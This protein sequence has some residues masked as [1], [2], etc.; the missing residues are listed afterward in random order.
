V[1]PK[2]RFRESGICS[3]PCAHPLPKSPLRASVKMAFLVASISAQKDPCVHPF[4]KLPLRASVFNSIKTKIWIRTLVFTTAFLK[5]RMALT[6]DTV[7][8]QVAREIIPV[9]CIPPHRQR[10]NYRPYDCCKNPVVKIKVSDAPT[11]MLVLSESENRMH[12]RV[13][14]ETDARKDL[15]E[16]HCAQPERLF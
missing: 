1:H 14:S 11:H 3:I 4:Q 6:A 10:L 9:D 15:F 12:A 7:R 2:C 5:Q 8:V 13:I 16:H